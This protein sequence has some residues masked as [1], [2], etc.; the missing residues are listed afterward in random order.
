MYKIILA[1]AFIFLVG[2]GNSDQGD[3]TPSYTYP[4][5]STDPQENSSSTNDQSSLIIDSITKESVYQEQQREIENVNEEN[6]TLAQTATEKQE[7]IDELKQQNNNL[8]NEI[9]AIYYSVGTKR[10]LLSNGIL[11]RG[12]FLSKRSLDEEISKSTLTIS[13]K[14]KIIYCVGS[15]IRNI[16]PDRSSDTYNIEDEC[17]YIT[18]IDGFWATTNILV[19]ET[20]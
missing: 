1:A 2:C 12:R 15:H 4:T 20:R 18:D 9:N 13:Y 11:E 10:E 3:S 6:L 16:Y 17:L 19:I 14:N 5:T 7:K 8:S